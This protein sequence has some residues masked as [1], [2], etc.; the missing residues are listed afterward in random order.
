[1]ASVEGLACSAATQG[2]AERATKLF[3]AMDT[4]Y[5]A[6]NYNETPE[7]R[8]GRASYLEA[9]RSQL[10]DAAWAEG[11]AMML[12]ETVSYALNEGACT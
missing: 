11:R 10:E 6:M 2:E 4:L 1:M 9:A 5:E 8:G 3:G 7:D 12:E